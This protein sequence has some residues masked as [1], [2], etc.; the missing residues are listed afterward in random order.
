M[1]GHSGAGGAGWLDRPWRDVPWVVVDVEGNGQ[2]PPDLV[3]AACLPIDHGEPGAPRTWL[4]L[5][6]RPITGPVTRIHGI[7]NS[8]ITDAPATADVAAEILAA[9]AGRVVVGHHVGVDLAVLHRE[10]D[11]WT[12]PEALDTLRL[13]KRV[14]PGLRSYRLDVL[15][16]RANPGPPAGAGQRHRAGHDTT[17]TA[18]L[19]LALVATIDASTVDSADQLTARQLLSYA[20]PAA[21]G[22]GDPLF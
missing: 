5:P 12:P 9:V 21:A 11:G 10:L 4:V 1:T 18:R 7:R 13:A 16:E 20:D 8:D 15:C 17:L 19:F 14:W 22:A 2:R 6:P 3:E